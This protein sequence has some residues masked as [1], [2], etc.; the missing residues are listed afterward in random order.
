MMTKKKPVSL[1]A[2]MT[3]DEPAPAVIVGEGATMTAHSASAPAAAP[4]V[5]PAKAAYEKA[6]VYMPSAAS[7]DIVGVEAMWHLLRDEAPLYS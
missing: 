3:G 6:T 4:T 2:M 7:A 5:K 1:E